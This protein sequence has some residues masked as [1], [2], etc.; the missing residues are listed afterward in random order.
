LFASIFHDRILLPIAFEV[1]KGGT[2][3]PPRPEYHARRF[4]DLWL[5]T[6]K[7]L[8]EAARLDALR[9]GVRPI[10]GAHMEPLA[11]V[12]AIELEVARHADALVPRGTAVFRAGS[13]GVPMDQ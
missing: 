7:L 8:D 12:P 6:P 4:P 5:V 1:A 11:V 2:S 3:F 10:V 9:I 13:V